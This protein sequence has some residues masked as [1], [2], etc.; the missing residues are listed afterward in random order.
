MSCKSRS[1]SLLGLQPPV[2]PTCL[3]PLRKSYTLA[4]CGWQLWKWPIELSQVVWNRHHCSW[5]PSEG[6]SQTEIRY[7]WYKWMLTCMSGTFFPLGKFIQ[8]I[9]IMLWKRVC[10]PR[11]TSFPCC[12]SFNSSVYFWDTVSFSPSWPLNHYVAMDG[13]ER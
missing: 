4:L 13:P 12:G 7:K 3:Q 1:L 5:Y 6:L 9:I 2:G 8:I 10:S 11:P